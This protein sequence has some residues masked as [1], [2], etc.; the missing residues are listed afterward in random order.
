[1]NRR[2]FLKFVAAVPAAFSILGSSE[3]FA[4]LY[5]FSE[6]KKDIVDMC[7]LQ[8]GQQI[9]NSEYFRKIKDFNRNFKDDVIASP[10][11][12][13]LIKSCNNKL[14]SLMNFVG[15]GNFNIISYDDALITMRSRSSLSEFTKEEKNFMEDFFSHN[16]ALYG[17]YG[18]R[19]F[20]NLYEKINE[21]NV[22]KIPYTGHYIYKG[23][24]E[25][26]YKKIT[27]DMNT[28]V[29]TS[30][31]RSVVKQAGLFLAKVV[32][33]K[34]NISMASRSIAPIG[35]SYHGIGDFDV[36]IKGWGHLN[37]TDKFATTKEYSKLMEGGYMRIRYDRKNPYGVRFEPWHVKVV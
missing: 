33:T 24:A 21:K 32:Q 3:A 8:D 12:Y 19:I 28:L 15:F 18:D 22:I 10:E 16:P 9:Y 29:L 13:T 25:A 36:G 14:R 5:P 30:G 23:K 1:M 26:T 6:E 4:L 35:Y 27:A 17:F 2:N 31:V 34:G 20:N 37:F 11:E 7:R